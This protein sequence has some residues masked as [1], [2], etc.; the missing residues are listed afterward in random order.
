MIMKNEINR[1]LGAKKKQYISPFTGEQTIQYNTVLCASGASD[2][3][4]S[5]VGIHGGNNSGDISDAF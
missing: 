3:I 4:S 1:A 5:N 2:R